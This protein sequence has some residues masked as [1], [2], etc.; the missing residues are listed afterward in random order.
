MLLR[1]YRAIIRITA[2]FSLY[3]LRVKTEILQIDDTFIL[4]AI[5]QQLAEAI[6]ARP[7]APKLAEAMRYAALGGGK[8]IRPLLTV[9]CGLAA[10]ACE[11]TS[12]LPA[13]ISFE[14]LHC[15][16]L[17]HDDLPALDNDDLRR[18]R[19]TTHKVYGEALAI[20]AG[21]ALQSL[22]METSLASPRHAA[23][24]AT[25]VAKACSD[26]IS[27]QVLDT[28]GGFPAECTDQASQLEM[29]HRHKTG[30]LIRGACRAGAIAAGASTDLLARLTRYGS[31]M[32]HMFQ[33][34]DDILDITQNS[35][36]LGKSAGK[37][38]A[39]GKTTYPS[40]HGLPMSRRFVAELLS[41]SESA[42]S[43]I[44][45]DASAL[46]TMARTLATRTH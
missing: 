27:G 33:V 14:L 40:V 11:L 5:E 24:I 21:D 19:P 42:L 28:L 17:V 12:L 3:F 29:I 43:G 25:E 46:S 9:R 44:E 18:G 15:F 6:E 34:V 7:L 37:D 32:G 4:Q 20:L 30:A 39:Q 16:S 22:A 45:A 8:R 31:A 38:S 36:T 13:A 1:S 10:G 2:C 23:A 41:E 26:M 35:Q